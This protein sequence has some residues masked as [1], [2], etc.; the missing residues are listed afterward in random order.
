MPGNQTCRFESVSSPLGDWLTHKPFPPPTLTKQTSLYEKFSI[1]AVSSLWWFWCRRRWSSFLRWI[2]ITLPIQ[3]YRK[4]F[5]F[6]LFPQP[7]IVEL[8]LIVKISWRLCLSKVSSAELIELTLWTS[9]DDEHFDDGH[10]SFGGHLL[11]WWRTSTFLRMEIYFF[12]DGNLLFWQRTSSTFLTKDIFFSKNIYFFGDGGE[13]LSVWDLKKM[14]VV[15][16][17]Y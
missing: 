17:D 16:L 9:F 5:I 15:P 13:Q 14:S 4:Y 3:Q 6:S 1:A 10:L 11:F 8:E 7:A 2:T 12:E